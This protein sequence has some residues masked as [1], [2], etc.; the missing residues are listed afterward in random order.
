MAHDAYV[1]VYG[2]D[3]PSPKAIRKKSE[4]DRWPLVVYLPGK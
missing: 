2:S 4:W 1:E 3:E